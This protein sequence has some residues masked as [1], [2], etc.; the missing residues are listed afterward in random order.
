MGLCFRKMEQCEPGSGRGRKN[1]LGSKSSSIWLE[2]RGV[3]V[4]KLRPVCVGS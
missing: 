1:Y 4:N 3:K 2:Y